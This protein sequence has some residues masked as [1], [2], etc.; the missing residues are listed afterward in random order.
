[1]TERDTTTTNADNVRECPQSATERL[2]AMLDERGVEWWD[3]YGD[4]ECTRWQANGLTWEYCSDAVLGLLAVVENDVTPEQAV[5]ATL[6]RGTC[7]VFLDGNENYKAYRC[8]ACGMQAVQWGDYC[9]SCGRR[10][11][12]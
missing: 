5:E 11:E 2:R 12:Q 9:P 7:H 6:G 10:V 3:P 4:G 8:D 1:M